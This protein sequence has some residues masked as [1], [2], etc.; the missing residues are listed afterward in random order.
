MGR[1]GLTGRRGKVFLN[2]VIRQNLELNTLFFVGLSGDQGPKGEIG[3]QGPA[4]RAGRD[5]FDGR[6]GS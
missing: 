3:N 6:K 1:P 2:I 4:G 5:G